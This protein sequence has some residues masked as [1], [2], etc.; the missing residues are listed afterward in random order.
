MP[1]GWG[2]VS[3]GSHP[4]NV[5][6]P[7]INASEGASLAAIYARDQD[8][9]NDF[10]QRHEVSS[11]YIS[12]QDFLKDPNVDIVYIASP[13][14]L[15][16]DQVV[17]AARAGKHILCEK[18][19]ALTIE[20]CETMVEACAKE[21]LKLGIAFQARQHP[22]NMKI[23]ELV[24]NGTLGTVALAHCQ[25]GYGEPGMVKPTVRTGLRGWWENSDIVGAG[26]FMANGVHAVDQLRYVVGSEVSEVSAMTDADSKAN[27]LEHLATLLL[28]FKN[29]T[30]ATLVSS[31]RL[32]YNRADLA[33][34]GSQGRAILTGGQATWKARLEIVDQDDERST[35]FKADQ[36]NLYLDLVNDFNQAVSE[37]SDPKATGW[38][39]L[40]TAQITLAMIES[41]KTGQTVR[42]H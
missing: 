14:S 36:G 26:T 6:A 2:I 40:K 20:D 4:N 19:M 41:S 39:G 8:R 24:Q 42:L 37:G 9:V 30:I 22:G 16:C 31:R 12:F 35:D 15:H 29:G 32:P 7:A 28:K 25:W 21:N 10:M 23:R 18:P 17:Q 33:V 3:A 34:Y 5:M 1:L 27:P 38:D 11:G 13:N